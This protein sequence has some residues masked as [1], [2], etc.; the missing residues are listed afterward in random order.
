MALT[1]CSDWTAIPLD[2][3]QGSAW[4]EVDNVAITQI[5]YNAT[6]DV[7]APLTADFFNCDATLASFTINLPSAAG[8]SGKQ[9]S[10]KKSDASANTITI[11]GSIDTGTSR[12]LSIQNDWLMVVSNDAVWEVISEDF[13][14]VSFS[15][16][17]TFTG[18]TSPVA[19]SLVGSYRR[20]RKN[21]YFRAS[22][23][24]SYSVAPTIIQ[25]TIPGALSSITGQVQT[26]IGR[27][28]SQGYALQGFSQVGVPTRLVLTKVDNNVPVTASG[29]VLEINGWIE[30][31]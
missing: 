17:V 28:V 7:T 20:H 1:A 3:Y 10:F 4:R 9:F 12:T 6:V 30:V 15:P 11:N 29:D 24:V 14:F 27:N 22:F 13:S 23:S 2:P 18:G 31:Q 16:V 19:G 5:V 25:M 21:L 8:N 26:V